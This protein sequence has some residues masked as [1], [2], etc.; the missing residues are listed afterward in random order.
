MAREDG[1]IDS[2][3]ALKVLELQEE[4]LRIGEELGNINFDDGSNVDDFLRV[5][6]RVTEMGRFM[7]THMTEDGRFPVSKGPELADMLE[8]WD[9]EAG[10]KMRKVVQNAIESGDEFIQ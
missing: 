8:K 10:E 9:S 2:K 4:I 1:S 7:A 5:T 3:D 6:E